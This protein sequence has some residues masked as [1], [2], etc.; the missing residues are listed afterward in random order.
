VSPVPEPKTYGMM[1]LG[2][3]LMGFSARRRMNHL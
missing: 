2:L 3:G 1:L